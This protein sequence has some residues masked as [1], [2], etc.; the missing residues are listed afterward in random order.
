MVPNLKRMPTNKLTTLL[1]ANRL[2]HQGNFTKFPPLH[3]CPALL[4]SNSWSK[5]STSIE[6]SCLRH[7]CQKS[8]TDWNQHDEFFDF[9]RARFIRDEE[10][11]LSQRRIKFNMNQLAQLCAKAIG[12][13]ACVNIEKYPDGMFSKAF[14]MTMD[15]GMQVVAKVPN[16]NAGR[17]HF[18]TASEVAT[19]DF[20]IDILA[21]KKL[22]S[23]SCSRFAMFVVHQCP[24]C[25]PGVPKL[26]KIRWALS[27]SSWKKSK[28]CN[29][30]R[31]GELYR[32]IRRPRL[33]R[34]LLA[35]KV[36]GCRIR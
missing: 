30:R 31:F 24:R 18:T 20:V 29:F 2:S 17:A 16:P 9:T 14:L 19:M 33:S 8:N 23:N 28:V 32:L 12:S 5:V 15:D 4:K 35:I 21:M 26:K 11:E 13:I 6:K 1:S 25:S 22:D 27:I 36:Y 10:W 7:L 34:H 3:P